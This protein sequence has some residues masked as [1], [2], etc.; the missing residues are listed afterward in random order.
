MPRSLI[1]EAILCELLAGA[2]CPACNRRDP[3]WTVS[4]EAVAVGPDCARLDLAVR[5]ACGDRVVKRIHMPVLQFAYVLLCCAAVGR[6]P[7]A[8]R[9]VQPELRVRPR[10]SEPFRRMLAEYEQVVADIVCWARTPAERDPPRQV[11]G[12][13]ATGSR[14]AEATRT[15]WGMDPQEWASFMHRI[16]MDGTEDA[17][18]GEQSPPGS[19]HDAPASSDESGPDRPGGSADSRPG[20]GAEPKPGDGAEPPPERE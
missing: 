2:V 13:N 1:P 4:H 18:A 3:T 20:A 16:G 15:L 14:D 19:R 5:C 9:A 6:S 12:D 11:P 17:A 8:P 10:R 7:A